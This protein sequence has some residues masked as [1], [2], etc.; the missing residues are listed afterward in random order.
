MMPPAP[1]T[2]DCI[3]IQL[4]KI[5]DVRGNLTYIEGGMHIPFAVRRA[6]WMYD[7]PGGEVRGGH[8]YRTL[9]EFVIALSGSFDLVLT[10][11]TRRRTVAMNRSYYGVFVPRLVWRQ[12]GNFSTN[13]VCLILAS[14]DYDESDYLRRYD[15]Y[16]AVRSGE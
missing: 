2:D 6:Y 8:A 11:G 4:P 9:Q 14:G 13:A 7:V 5:P 3:T 16:L 1:T 10:D 15:E 12:V